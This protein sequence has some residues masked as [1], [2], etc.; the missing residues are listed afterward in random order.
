MILSSL[1]LILVTTTP[2]AQMHFWNNSGFV[3]NCLNEEL[4]DRTTSACWSTND[5]L[6]FLSSGR[7]IIGSETELA[8]L[9]LPWNRSHSGA[10]SRVY[11][12][13]G[14]GV[15]P[16]VLPKGTQNSF[17]LPSLGRWKIPFPWARSMAQDA[18]CVLNVRF[19]VNPPLT[20]GSFRSP[21]LRIWLAGYIY[22]PGKNKLEDF[23]SCNSYSSLQIV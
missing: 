22:L 16:H 20:Q 4:I 1:A 23:G 2:T 17:M 10:Q 13:N 6:T 8:I 5:V 9:A 7:L 11:H 18:L 14:K 15:G 3:Q 19:P 12:G 21:F